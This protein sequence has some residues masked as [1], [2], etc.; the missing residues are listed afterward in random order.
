VLVLG[1]PLLRG[2]ATLIAIVLVDD[3]STA[4]YPRYLNPMLAP[5]VLGSVWAWPARARRAT[6]RWAVR[7]AAASGLALA[8]VWLYMAGAHYFV[9]LGAHFGIRAAAG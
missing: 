2:L 3:W 7:I 8:F 9:H 1:G 5:F 6:P 4:L